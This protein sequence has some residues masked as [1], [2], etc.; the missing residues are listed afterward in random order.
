MID[1]L[2]MHGL[3]A[4]PDDPDER[5]FPIDALYAARDIVPTPLDALPASYACPGMPP[6]LDQGTS[7]MCVAYSSSA[8]KA[9][10]DGQDQ[11]RF[12]DFDEPRF[13][14]EI[15]GTD[16]GA[17]ARWAMERMRTRSTRRG[18]SARSASSRWSMPLAVSR[19]RSTSS[20]CTSSGMPRRTSS[21]RAA[22]GSRRSVP[23]HGSGRCRQRGERLRFLRRRPT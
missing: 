6:V 11:L 9:R 3:G 19:T 13:F 8:V 20:G 16:A 4:I 15:G 12:F 10:Q 17:Q 14:A 21:A 2:S 1:D 7:P 22:M 18:S 5:D 23:W